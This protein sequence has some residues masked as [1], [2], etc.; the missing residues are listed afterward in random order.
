[1]NLL[2]D[3]DGVLISWE[4]PLNTL[5]STGFDDFAKVDK[6]H[7]NHLSQDQLCLIDELF[8]DSIHWLTTW[9]I[10]YAAMANHSFCPVVGWPDRTSAVWPNGRDGG[11]L[12][13]MQPDEVLNWWKAGI[14]SDLLF[15][16]HP[17]VQ[18]KVV[19]VDDELASHWYEV[20]PMLERHSAFG[21]FRCISPFPAWSRKEIQEA[22]EWANA[23]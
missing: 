16:D 7:F 19:W 14:V 10:G 9:E 13:T 3:I 2:L 8:G 4:A 17:F 23:A 6:M 22:Y 12:L 21:R 18:G 5:D 15:N 1:M 20:K 11:S